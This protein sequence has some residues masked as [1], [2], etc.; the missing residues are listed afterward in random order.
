LKNIR[1]ATIGMSSANTYILLKNNPGNKKI[2]DDIQKK[3][4]L[5][6][7]EFNKLN[8]NILKTVDKLLIEKNK[9]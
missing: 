7:R 9:Y 2:F 6:S 3:T 1:T 5:D 8:N 4:T